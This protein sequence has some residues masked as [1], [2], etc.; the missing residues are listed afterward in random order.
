LIDYS[1]LVPDNC[2]AAIV[3]EGRAGLTVAYFAVRHELETRER[4]DVE[5]FSATGAER[6]EV[7]RWAELELAQLAADAEVVGQ[8]VP[9]AGDGATSAVAACRHA[10][11]PG[12]VMQAASAV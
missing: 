12:V 10:L 7:D 3:G 6:S 5:E 4:L 1:F 2:D 9:Y 8:A 11:A